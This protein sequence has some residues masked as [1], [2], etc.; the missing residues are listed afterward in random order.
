MC[1]LVIDHI[2]NLEGLFREMKRICK[3]DGFVLVSVMH[4]AMML[5]GV[6]ARVHGSGNRPTDPAGQRPQPDM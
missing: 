5:R 4:P 1:G 6:Q 3:P 2:A